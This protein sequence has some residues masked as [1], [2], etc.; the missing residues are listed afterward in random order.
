MFS[1]SCQ[2]CPIIYTH[3]TLQ[4]GMAPGVAM[5]T[6]HNHSEYLKGKLNNEMHDTANPV[7]KLLWS[8]TKKKTLLYS[9]TVL[10]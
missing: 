1:L 3:L 7:F 6:L 9:N 2:N 10:L 8:K 4:G 5:A